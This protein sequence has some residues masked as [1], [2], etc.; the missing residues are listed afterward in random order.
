MYM[1]FAGKCRK[2][3][4]QF[5]VRWLDPFDNTLRDRWLYTDK[6]ASEFA[7]ALEWDGIRPTEIQV[8]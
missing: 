7:D 5:R 1:Q 3:R 6:A 2:S 8:R 4:R